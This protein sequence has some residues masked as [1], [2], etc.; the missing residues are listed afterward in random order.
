[1]FLKNLFKRF[2]KEDKGITGTDIAVSI[3]IIVVTMVVVTTIYINVNNKVKENIRYSNGVRIATQI[4]ENIQLKNFDYLVNTCTSSNTENV[5]YTNASG[6]SGVKLFGVNIP[7]GYFA[8]ITT[9]RVS[10][11]DIDI[12]RDVTVEVNYKVSKKTNNITLYTTK[13]KELLEQSNKPDISLLNKDL[14]NKN[15]YPIKYYN[16]K[17]YITD[18]ND[19]EWYNYDYN[20]S[21]SDYGKYA[22][23]YVT[24]SNLSIGANVDINFNGNVYAWIPRFGIAIENGESKLAYCYGTSNYKIGFNKWTDSNGNTLYGYMLCG[25]GITQGNPDE[26]SKYVNN[27]FTLGDGLTGV[28]YNVT[29]TSNNSLLVTSIKNAFKV[30]CPYTN[31]DISL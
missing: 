27:T 29:D 28:W 31:V 26:I 14:N 20:T 10:N 2:R 8:T 7:T 25:T 4:V 17:Y 12:I 18:I 21:N 3:M 22:L 16:E 23:V 24:S 5:F 13:E 15:I 1:M 6:G 9:K 30:Y 19:A 11:T